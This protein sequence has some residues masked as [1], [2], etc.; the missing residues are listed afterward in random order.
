MKYLPWDSVGREVLP[1]LALVTI[2]E[3]K[4]HPVDAPITRPQTFAYLYETA[5]TRKLSCCFNR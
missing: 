5:A 2:A 4:A 3:A 1:K